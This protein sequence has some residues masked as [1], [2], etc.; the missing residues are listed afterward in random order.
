MSAGIPVIT[1]EKA[2][3]ADFVKEHQVGIVVDSLMELSSVLNEITEEQYAKMKI[4]AE[5][6]GEKLRSGFYF[7]KALREIFDIE[8]AKDKTRSVEK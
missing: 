5:M 7:R 8:T 4:N 3:I 1:W 2:A 6:I